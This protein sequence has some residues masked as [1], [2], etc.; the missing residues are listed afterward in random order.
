L[1]HVTFRYAMIAYL[2][3]DDSLKVAMIRRRIQTVSASQPSSRSRVT[4]RGWLTPDRGPR[5]VDAGVIVTASAATSSV[6]RASPG[7][8]GRAATDPAARY[9]RASAAG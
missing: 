4:V 9:D 8:T 2:L 6:A 1:T 5:S 3:L 7:G